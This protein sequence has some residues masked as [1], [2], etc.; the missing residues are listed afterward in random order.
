MSNSFPEALEATGTEEQK[1]PG[2]FLTVNSCSPER[3][4][5][6]GELRTKEK[7]CDF[8]SSTLERHSLLYTF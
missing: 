8:L 3:V 1:C 2:N 5:A 4:G 6:Q 7:G